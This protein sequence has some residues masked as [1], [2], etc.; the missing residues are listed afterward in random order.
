MFK[1]FIRGANRVSKRLIRYAVTKSTPAGFQQLTA[2]FWLRLLA[3]GYPVAYLQPVFASVQHADRRRYL[4]N[5]L[6][7]GCSSRVAPVLVLTN[8]KFETQRINLNRVMNSVYTSFKYS[9]AELGALFVA[10]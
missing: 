5:T 9:S 3:R 8:G 1:A 10:R 6:A 7:A 4:Q 2:T